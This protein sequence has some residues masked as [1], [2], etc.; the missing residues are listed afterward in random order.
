MFRLLGGLVV[1]FAFAALAWMA[2]LPF[3]VTERIRAR[4]GFEATVERLVAN[5]FTG[6]IEVR[7]L[8]L[9]NPAEFPVREFVEVRSLRAEVRLRSLWG[10]RTEFETVAVD[11]GAVTLVKSPSGAINAEVFEAV[12]AAGKRAFLVR[13]LRL[14]V[15]RLVVADHSRR[16]P[17]T[18]EQAL[19]MDAVFPEVTE[20]E[21]V[22]TT[23]ALQP[24]GAVA[25]V[26][27][28]LVPGEWGTSV[29]AVARSGAGRLKDLG[30]KAG[31]GVKGFFDALEE[32]KKP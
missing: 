16:T 3:V 6:E 29:D 27:L 25:A 23:P 5:P 32:S 19:D 22:A 14:K 28:Q 26:L 2:L 18:R 4:T 21:Q 15:G 20:V 17:T 13:T 10:A 9:R 11:V 24:L 30:R 12:P 31:E 1:V 8:V 7:G